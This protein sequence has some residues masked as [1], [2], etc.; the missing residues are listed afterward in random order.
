MLYGDVEHFSRAF[1]VAARDDRRM[2]IGEAVALKIYVR[3]IAQR[4]TDALN[5]EHRVGA[6]AQVRHR[7]QELQ[8]VALLLQGVVGGTLAENAI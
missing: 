6:Y 7:A 5:V 1:A 4:R 3:G 2:N 8:R